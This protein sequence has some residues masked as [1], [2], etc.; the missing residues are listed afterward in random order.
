[1]NNNIIFLKYL[2]LIKIIFLFELKHLSFNLIFKIFIN[3]SINI[4]WKYLTSKQKKKKRS[5]IYD[6][7]S[8]WKK[9]PLY[10]ILIN[11][12]NMT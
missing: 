10:H 8:S 5:N 3:I 4:Y 6:F 12:I 7:R 1:M 11:Y 9:I 2:I